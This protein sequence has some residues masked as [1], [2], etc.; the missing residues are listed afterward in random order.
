MKRTG[1]CALLVLA[2]LAL[3]A[4]CR[5]EKGLQAETTFDAFIQGLY[6]PEEGKHYQVENGE[7]ADIT[8]AFIKA[9]QTAVDEEDYTA[10]RQYA[11]E[12]GVTI[13]MYTEPVPFEGRWRVDTK[14]Y[15][16]F[17]LSD[18]LKENP[19]GITLCDGF[20]DVY[21]VYDVKDG[22][23]REEQ[24]RADG[25]IYR[26]GPHSSSLFF[27]EH[28]LELTTHSTSSDWGVLPGGKE[29]RLSFTQG[30]GPMNFP[31]EVGAMQ[32]SYVIPVLD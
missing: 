29:I 1:L 11:R 30:F 21:L 6:T 4:G 23:A 27:M 32:V 31:G 20:A 12:Q 16:V 9:T 7:Q 10:V 19:T 25:S 5:R 28:R 15:Q 22:M 8:E 13:K 2:L 14:T 17:N 18:D 26:E 24:V 3:P